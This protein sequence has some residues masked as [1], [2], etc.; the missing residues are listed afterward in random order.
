MPNAI[1]SAFH[2]VAYLLFQ[3]PHAVGTTTIPNIGD[4]IV[5]QRG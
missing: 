5:V 4:E 2:V 3:Q 1:L